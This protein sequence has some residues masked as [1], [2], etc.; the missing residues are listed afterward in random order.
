MAAAQGNSRGNTWSRA[1]DTVSADDP[2]FW[3]FSWDDMAEYDLPATI[4]AVLRLTGQSRIGFVG[5][6]GL[7]RDPRLC[8]T[9]V[10]DWCAGPILCV[11]SCSGVACSC[12]KPASD[13]DI[14]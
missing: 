13:S 8:W 7:G 1:H 5:E 3:D 12:D 9:L 2:S 4:A 14:A 10:A 11:T 6:V